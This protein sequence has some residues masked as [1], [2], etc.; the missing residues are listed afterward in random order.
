M[1]HFLY[2]LVFTVIAFVAIGNLIRNLFT[3]GRESNRSLPH[4]GLENN[5]SMPQPA[6][7]RASI[8]HP[9]LLDSN[10]KPINEPLL[11]MR[12]VDVEEARERLDALYRS[13]PGVNE[14]EG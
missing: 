8:P 1:L 13:S 6:T 7:R 10:G 9:E 2:I 11:V 5:T 3:L 12:S 14:N 4:L